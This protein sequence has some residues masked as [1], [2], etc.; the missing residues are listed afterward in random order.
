MHFSVNGDIGRF[1]NFLWLWSQ[2]ECECFLFFGGGGG[3][4][5]VL[6]FVFGLKPIFYELDRFDFK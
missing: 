1:F 4:V 3:G 5:Y 2:K 6:F